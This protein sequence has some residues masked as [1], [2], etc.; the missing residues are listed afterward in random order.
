MSD[1]HTEYKGREI[2]LYRGKND[3]ISKI[4]IIRLKLKH[5][6]VTEFLT[7]NKYETVTDEIKTR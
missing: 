3:N 6:Y 2:P 1:R 7:H 4:R 5:N